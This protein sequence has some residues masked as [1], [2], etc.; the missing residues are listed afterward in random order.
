LKEK[1]LVLKEL[2]SAEND[3]GI[4]WFKRE[5]IAISDTGEIPAINPEFY[6]I[7]VYDSVEADIVR[8]RFLHCV[9]PSEGV[10]QHLYIKRSDSDAT[11]FIESLIV[12]SLLLSF[13]LVI[14]YVLVNRWLV[15]RL[16]RAFDETLDQLKAFDIDS[17]SQVVLP[18][19]HIKEF[20]TLNVE[21]EALINKIR[22]N[23]WKHKEFIAHASL[24]QSAQRR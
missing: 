24:P 10:P 17:P 19:T 16:W 14:L 22:G 6:V 7:E 1:D 21:V 3:Q 23:C 11:S 18:S 12:T 2:N 13:A 4:D 8:C 5:R 20:Q 9:L 15:N